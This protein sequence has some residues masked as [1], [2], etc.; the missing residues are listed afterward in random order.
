M[1]VYSRAQDEQET[2]DKKNWLTENVKE[3][4]T[5]LKSDGKTKQ[6]LYQ[7]IYTGTGAIIARGKYEDNKR[8]GTWLF[9]DVHQ[10]LI[11]TFDYTRNELLGEEPIDAYSKQFIRYAFDQHFKDT[12]RVTKPIRIGGR[13]FGY[14]PYLQLFHLSADYNNVDPRLL[15][16]HL[17]LLISPGGRLADL[18][19]H[20]IASDNSERVTTISPEIF[21]E[22]DRQF[23]PAT[24][25]GQPVLSRIFVACRVTEAG[26]LDVD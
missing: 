11:E 17:E 15:M 6:G 23:V 5:V 7:A 22:E 25:N 18:K 10:K 19:I 14:I 3:K 26:S 20:I 24:V 21:S 2:T 8:T 9:F 4:F 16:A 13:C 1:A 12:D